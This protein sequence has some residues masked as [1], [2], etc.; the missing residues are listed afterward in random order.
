MI[1]FYDYSLSIHILLKSLYISPNWIARN[2]LVVHISVFYTFRL[3]ALLI[4]KYRLLSDYFSYAEWRRT[5]NNFAVKS[6]QRR[7]DEDMLREEE[8]RS[9]SV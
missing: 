7:P 4:L 8:I 1:S 2:S 6:G 3:G 5:G 9:F